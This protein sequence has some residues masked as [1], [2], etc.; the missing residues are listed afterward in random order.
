[1]ARFEV[2]VELAWPDDVR[3]LEY[4]R[5]EEGHGFM[6]EYTAPAATR[7]ETC[8][9]EVPTAAN[10]RNTFYA[11][12][13]LDLWGEPCFLLY[14]PLQ[15]TCPGCG[16]RQHVTP[17]WKRK[18]VKYTL[19]FEQ[20]V[21][22]RLRGSTVEEVA[23]DFGVDAATVE[24]IVA[25]QIADAKAQTVDPERVLLDLG[26]DE[27]SLKKRHR[28]YATLLWD[29]TDP[30]QPQLLAAAEGRDEAAARTCLEHLSPAQRAAVRTLRSDMGPAMLSGLKLLPK[31]QSVID[32][33]HVAQKLG[34]VV[35]A[36]RKKRPALTSAA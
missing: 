34:A 28:L 5:L 23:K 32:R 16:H 10:P 25:A 9:R 17:V 2:M 30:T 36:L 22:R 13:D 4:R 8:G 11:A 33:F 18:D 14:Q 19:R 1:M 29:L 24:R 12:R 3:V 7:C 35:D 26:I 31:A 6:V 27:I 15:H 20:A 21:L